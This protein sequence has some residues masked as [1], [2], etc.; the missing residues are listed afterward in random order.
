MY[1]VHIKSSASNNIEFDWGDGTVQT[2]GST[3][4]SGADIAH[5]YS[6]TGDYCITLKVKSGTL[7]LY[8][9]G[10]SISSGTSI[11]GSRGSSGAF[12]ERHML[13]KV[14]IG[15]SVTNIENFYF[16]ACYKLETITIPTN[17]QVINRGAFY[18]C[19]A[20][21]A[22]V[23]PRTNSSLTVDRDVFYNCYSMIAAS[24][25]NSVTSVGQN[26]FQSCYALSLVGLPNSLTDIPT[27]MFNYCSALKAVGVGKN[28]TSIGSSAFSGCYA[29]VSAVVASTSTSLGS[30]A[31][32]NCYSL[33]SLVFLGSISGTMGNSAISYC[34]SLESFDIP[35][36]VT[37][38]PTS[39]LSGAYSLKSVTIPSG[40]TTI[41][42]E[43]FRYAYSLS[44]ITIPASVTSIG[45]S[46]FR[47]SSGVKEYHFKSMTPPTLGDGNV[48]YNI[49]SDCKIYVPYSE[50]HSVLN[51]Y[52][53]ATN[54]SSQASKMVEERIDMIDMVA[55]I[56]A[57]HG[58]D[59]VVAQN[60]FT[61]N[62]TASDTFLRTLQDN[63]VCPAGT[64]EFDFGSLITS[65]N[66][67]LQLF[68]VTDDVI[69]YSFGTWD[70]SPTYTFSLSSTKTLR[71]RTTTFADA[72]V[73]E[74][75]ELHLRATG[76]TT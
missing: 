76:G 34:Y 49:Q 18:Q 41:G 3:A 28:V 29:L 46:T 58:I 51:A 43:T 44:K 39:M 20:L 68:N 63:I 59:Y 37:A 32:S 1:S 23:L 50:D 30:S 66:F 5:T 52:K 72:V 47:E 10:T 36:G 53:T 54:W 27:N 11:Y 17:I 55:T 48:F 69:I 62:G 74:D 4:S 61:A 8:G 15:T 57:D 60:R 33:K 21:K 73:D 40:L 24:I 2:T 75:H 38:T 45:G 7:T 9:V 42:N 65:S 13:R 70:A 16:A 31:F 19:Y 26:A 64:Y 56:I 71:I 14:E 6:N 25:S 35:N 22:I 67:M 12:F